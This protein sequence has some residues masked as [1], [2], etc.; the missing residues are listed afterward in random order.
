MK[1]KTRI[2][3]YILIAIA[4]LILGTIAILTSSKADK[5]V[6]AQEHIDLGNVYLIELSYDKAILEFTEAIEI[7]PLN[8]DAYLGLAEAYVGM[9][10]TEKAVEVLEEG[11]D[12]TGDERLKDMLEELLPH[13]PE[14]TT[15]TTTTVAT[16]ETTT[17]STVAM[18]TVPNLLGLTEEE[19]ISACESAGL[20]YSISYDYSDEVEKGYV[21]GQTIPV[22]VSVAEGVSVPFKVSNGTKAYSVQA[23]VKYS[24]GDFISK[25]MNYNENGVLIK[26]TE[27]NRLGGKCVY[28]YRDNGILQKKTQYYSSNEPYSFCLYDDNEHI[29]ENGIYKDDGSISEYGHY[30]YKN[31]Y[32]TLGNIISVSCLYNGN[33]WYKENYIY[34]NGKCIEYE[35]KS[36]DGYRAWKEYKYDLKG[37][38]IQELGWK[39]NNWSEELD[40]YVKTSEDIYNS[41][42]S[43]KFEKYVTLYYDKDMVPYKTKYYDYEI[44][45]P[46]LL[47]N[48][49]VW[50][51]DQYGHSFSDK[52]TADE[53][54]RF[55]Y[56]KDSVTVY[57]NASKIRKYDLNGLNPKYINSI[58]YIKD[59]EYDVNNYLIKE[60]SYSFD[61][62][63]GAEIEETIEYSYNSVGNLEK[64]TET[65]WYGTIWECFYDE[66]GNEIKRLSSDGTV[67][68]TEYVKK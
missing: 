11:Y 58:N 7:E 28:E 62:L 23:V 25:E 50:N 8:S 49:Y 12:K 44:N 14:V 39:D 21:I 3:I 4:V 59:Y 29:I 36:N 57:H 27:Y 1:Q 6:P 10:D 60:I 37:N 48:I 54:Y 18:A 38:V 46:R 13:E 22:N 31:T 5:P 61:V 40:Y 64:K 55:S 35:S 16:E 68:I 51:D 52:E 24:S 20:K 32:D 65:S 15:V 17:V 66:N 45:Q 53:V 30:K 19:A 47:N 33:E 9:G 67:I 42:W 26:M 41:H 63:T 43:D 56:D 34:D 2:L